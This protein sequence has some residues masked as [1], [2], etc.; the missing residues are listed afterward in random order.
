MASITISLPDNRVAKL[1]KIAHNFGV[2][3]EDL[4]GMGIEEFLNRP[5]E[6][7]QQAMNYVL[8]KNKELYERLSK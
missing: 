2:T 5:E 8:L 6:S 4:V 3:P 1:K 7:F